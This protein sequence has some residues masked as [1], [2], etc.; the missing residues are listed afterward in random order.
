MPPWRTA[1]ETL[2]SRRARSVFGSGACEKWAAWGEAG[3][4]A[5]A[6]RASVNES[7]SPM[8]GRFTQDFTWA[9]L[10]A[11][12]LL[13]NPALPNLKSSWNIAPTEDAGVIVPQDGGRVYKTMRWGLVPFWAKDTKIGNQALNARLETAASKPVFREAWK[14]RRCLVP[15]SGYY[16][17]RTL[18]APATKGK[19]FKQPFYISRKDGAPLTFAGLWERWRDG[20]LTFTIL[21]T[22]AF[23]R[24]RDLHTR[25]PVMLGADDQPA[26]LGGDMPALA[27]DLDTAIAVH[28]VSTRVNRPGHDGAECIAPLIALFR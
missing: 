24:A 9:D 1:D 6:D 8:C 21:T 23:E 14:A 12:Y 7:D 17:W 16:E 19:P 28:P 20:L 25:M 27:K 2:S 10:E 13:S 22:E 5:G 26:W 3:R 15:A 18:P 4:S 11:F